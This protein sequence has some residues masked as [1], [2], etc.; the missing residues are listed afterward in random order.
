MAEMSDVS[1]YIREHDWEPACEG[2]ACVESRA[3]DGWVYLRNSERPEEV[4]AFTEAEWLAAVPQLLYGD[5]RFMRGSDE[6]LG[7]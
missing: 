7:S 5:I 6:L 2:G 3:Y 4:V 1:F